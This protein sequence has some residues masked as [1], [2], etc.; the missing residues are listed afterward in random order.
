MHGPIWR[1]LVVSPIESRG[2]PVLLGPEIAEYARPVMQG[3]RITN[4]TSGLSREMEKV[5]TTARFSLC[6]SAIAPV[7]QH[8]DAAAL[9]ESTNTLVRIRPSDTIHGGCAR[10]AVAVEIAGIAV[11]G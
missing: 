7:S 10:P 8:N 6:A 4:G 9:G 1:A 5:A 3:V 2:L 11:F